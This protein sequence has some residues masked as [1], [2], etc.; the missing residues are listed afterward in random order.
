MP[1]KPQ[2]P[3]VQAAARRSVCCE[4]PHLRRKQA[5]D[6][7]TLIITFTTNEYIDADTVKVFCVNGYVL[8]NNHIYQFV[9]RNYGTNNRIRQERIDEIIKWTKKLIIAN[10]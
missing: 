5:F 2:R 9:G 3:T 6:G 1:R 7:Q 8:L 4:S 10:K